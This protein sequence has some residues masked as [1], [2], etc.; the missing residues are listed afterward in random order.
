[1][2]RILRALFINNNINNEEIYLDCLEIE[3]DFCIR[4]VNE[5]QSKRFY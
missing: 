5:I 4:A 2:Q 1:M 3:K